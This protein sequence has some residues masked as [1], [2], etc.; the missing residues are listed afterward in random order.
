MYDRR[1]QK[2]CYCFVCRNDYIICFPFAIL[3]AILILSYDLIEKM[4]KYTVTYLVH[5]MKILECNLYSG[6]RWEDEE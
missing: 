4:T 2:M 1:E 5:D 6:N 3:I